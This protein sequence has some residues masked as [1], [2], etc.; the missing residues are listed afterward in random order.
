MRLDIEL[1]DGSVQTIVTDPSWR[2]SNDGPI[3][4]TGI[5]YGETYDAT[6]EMPGWDQP[7][8]AAAGWSPALVLPC[9][10]ESEK[11]IL[12]AQCND[13]IRVDEER[14][15]VKMTEPTARRLRLRHGPE[16]DRLVPADGR[17]SGGNQNHRALRRDAQ[18]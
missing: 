4:R 6:K 8:F 7:G 13:P 1:A 12:A 5:Y 3:R 11:A 17:R 15:A 14:P 10:H 2:T 16:H 18:R 9:P